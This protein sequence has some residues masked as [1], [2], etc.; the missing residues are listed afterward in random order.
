MITDVRKIK[1]NCTKFGFTV[2]LSVHACLVGSPLNESNILIIILIYLGTQLLE[3]I[4]NV[5]RY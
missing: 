5:D 1:H 3:S 2:H 4:L